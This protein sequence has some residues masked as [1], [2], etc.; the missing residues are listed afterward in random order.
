MFLNYSFLKSIPVIIFN[1]WIHPQLR[2]SFQ[3]GLVMIIIPIQSSISLDLVFWNQL[4]SPMIVSDQYQHSKSKDW[5]N[6]KLSKSARIH[7]HSK[8]IVLEIMLRNHSTY[9]IANHWNRFKSVN[10]VSVIML[11]NLNWRIYHNYN[12]FKLVQLEVIHTISVGVHLW[13]EVLNWYWIL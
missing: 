4:K 12:P 2:L 10:V 8:R 13:F 3:I 6:W 9:W 7:L 5:I 11:A 1:H